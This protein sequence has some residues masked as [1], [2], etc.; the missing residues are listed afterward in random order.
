MGQ[1]DP[2]W[3]DFREIW[4]WELFSRICRG[5]SFHQNLTGIR[6]SSHEDQCTLMVS[7]R[8]IFGM[9]NVSDR[10]CKASQTPIL[11]SVFPPPLRNRVVYEI[12]WKNIVEWGRPQ[13]T[14]WRMR[15]ACWITEATD[16]HKHT[17]RNVYLLLFHSNSGY[18][19]AP[20]CYDISTL[21]VLLIIY[22][23]HSVVGIMA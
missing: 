5:N 8:I 11:Y 13:T 3:T 20:Q 12:M 6:E 16:T 21:P 15:F 9:W 14:V 18:A 4:Y 17:L 10:T 7:C 2:H 22:R 23:Q 19:N 1:F